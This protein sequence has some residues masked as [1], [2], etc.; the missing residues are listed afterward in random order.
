MPVIPH[1]TARL[2]EQTPSRVVAFGSSNTERRQTGMHWFDLFELGCRLNYWDTPLA[3]INSGRGGD[4]TDD[5]LTRFERDCLAYRPHLVF[6]TIGG[7]DSSLY[8]AVTPEAFRANLLTLIDG[9][10]AIDCEVVLQTYYAC[11]VTAMEPG[12]ATRLLAFMDIIRA[13]SA[14]PEC[15]LV[16]HLAQW[17]PLRQAAH[18][19]YGRLMNDAMHV[20]ELG[21]LV[22]GLEIARAFAFT[23]PDEPHLREARALQTLMDR[24][25]MA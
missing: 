15:G 9:L 20:N 10:R 25:R 11:E 19:V 2:A 14:E 1:F 23:L 18:D 6:L 13:V 21:N 12:H 5:L 7:N 22:M 3:C 8:R 16:D 17:E 4:T 24:L